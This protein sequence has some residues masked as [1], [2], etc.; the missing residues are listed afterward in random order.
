MSASGSCKNPPT[1]PASIAVGPVVM[2]GS[3]SEGVK[4]KLCRGQSPELPS[5]CTASLLAPAKTFEVF[6][7]RE[8]HLLFISRDLTEC[9]KCLMVAQRRFLPLNH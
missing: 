5:P 3:S 4:C 7:K 2:V 6:E 8:T 9:L 1:L